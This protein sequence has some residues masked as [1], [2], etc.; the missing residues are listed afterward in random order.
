[1]NKEF[2]KDYQREI[3]DEQDEFIENARRGEFSS[4]RDY[5]LNRFHK[6]SLPIS[7]IHASFYLWE[8]AGLKWPVWNF[9]PLS[10]TLVVSLAPAPSQTIFERFHGFKVNEIP[11]LVEYVRNE[12]K[13]QFVLRSPPTRYEHMDFLEPIFV[14]LKPPLNLRI[15]PEAYFDPKEVKRFRVEFN[16]LAKI[17]YVPH[18]A[19]W[20]RD[21]FG[22]FY[23]L[24]EILEDVS[25]K[26]SYIRGLAY[27]QL[28][29][30]IEDA[31][32]S[33][34][35]RF[36]I[37]ITLGALLM[38]PLDDP[39]EKLLLGDADFRETQRRFFDINVLPPS[40]RF[41]PTFPGE[42]GKFL[43][44]KLVHATPT[45]ESCKQLSYLYDE[46]DIYKVGQALSQAIEAKKP[47]IVKEKSEEISIIFENIWADK[48]VSRH[49]A[50][51]KIGFRVLFAAIGAVSHGLE[52]LGAGL[53]ASFGFDLADKLFKF[54]DEAISERIGKPFSSSYETILYDFKKK[55]PI[56]AS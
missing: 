10:R 30:K 15:L 7:E 19:R 53:L 13:L 24:F 51:V 47:E 55:Y 48:T 14:H 20:C 3:L 29:D 41:K 23:P 42:I 2:L 31:L 25:A 6:P 27:D 4:C 36:H 17:R 22:S 52:G 5:Y 34:V 45:L 43:F 1:M 44:E 54:K 12:G 21:F 11:D 33:D 38:K 39:L 49:I 50:G 8:E 26:Y 56:T 28:I 37:L 46:E 40:G 16:E 35:D 18:I 9:V 32:I